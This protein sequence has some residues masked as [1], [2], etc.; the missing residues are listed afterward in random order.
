MTDGI[1]PQLAQPDPRGW[2][3]F[4]SLPTDIGNAEDATA[5]ADHF[6]FH[7]HTVTFRFDRATRTW[8]FERPA[9]AAERALLGHPGYT[10]P[11]ELDTR[12]SY[13]TETVRRRTW[14]QLQSPE[15]Q[16]EGADQHD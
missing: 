12:V 6:R 4:A 7:G 14:P 1:G 16:L 5:H 11:E 13:A 3:V 2:L 15:H 9:T 10:L 8:F